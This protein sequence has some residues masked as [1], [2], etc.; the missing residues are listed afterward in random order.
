MKENTNRGENG[1]NSTPDNTYY[2]FDA[3]EDMMTSPKFTQN[4]SGNSTGRKELKKQAR[5]EDRMSEST[6]GGSCCSGKGD[7]TTC[8]IF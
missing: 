2:N 7:N 4:T 1:K 8:I 5:R 3:E 6:G